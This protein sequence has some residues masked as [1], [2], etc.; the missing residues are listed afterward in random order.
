MLS[1]EDNNIS[2]YVSYM[3]YLLKIAISQDV[4]HIIALSQDMYAKSY[5][6]IAYSIWHSFIRFNSHSPGAQVTV[7]RA[8][9]VHLWQPSFQYPHAHQFYWKI[10][11]QI[12][13]IYLKDVFN[14]EV[15]GNMSILELYTCHNCAIFDLLLWTTT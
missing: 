9:I 1:T 2:R 7:W 3:C 8:F 5:Q 15:C 10:K 6:I 13:T 11:I 12:L 14:N 4:F